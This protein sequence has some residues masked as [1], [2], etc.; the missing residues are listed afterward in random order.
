MINIL[1]NNNKY[2]NMEW[3]KSLNNAALKLNT[4]EINQILEKT[5]Y[6]NSNQS[7]E[8]ID[9]IITTNGKLFSGKGI[10]LGAGA[11][12]FSSSISKISNV[13]KIY[14]LEIIENYVKL[15]QPKIIKNFGISKKV[16]PT[17]GTF[18]DLSYFK[19]EYFDFIFQYDAFHHA[20]DLP[21][22][23]N[24]CHRVL[25]KNGKIISIDRIQSDRISNDMINRKL[26]I[27]YTKEYFYKHCKDPIKN[28]TR[29]DNGE[30][31]IR[32][33]EWYSY[34]RNSQFMNIKITDYINYN[35]NSFIKL[36][37]SYLP[38]FILKRTKFR[39]LVGESFVSYIGGF[40]KKNK[41]TNQG[42]FI[43]SKLQL[44]KDLAVLI[45]NK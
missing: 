26:E 21:K 19:D 16:I 25:K 23:L 33:N 36:I 1:K 24:E 31:E 29:R 22:V 13:E 9:S 12:L 38:D 41:P 3:A 10:E 42:K 39:Y 32:R 45:C 18:D 5:I 44:H 27:L 35:F 37:L 6:L 4:L 14:S 43:N 28:Y 15:L 8:I 17:R 2:S 20:Y 11:G 40:M 34:F 30:H 7:K